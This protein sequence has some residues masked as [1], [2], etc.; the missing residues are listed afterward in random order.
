M[1]DSKKSGWLR[2]RQWRKALW[3]SIP[4]F[5]V[6]GTILSTL[7]LPKELGVLLAF[8]PAFISST[9]LQHYKCPRCGECFF[10]DRVWYP[11]RKNCAHCGLPKWE[12]ADSAHSK[13][14]NSHPE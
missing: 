6:L 3:V 4:G 1:S 13:N 9:A 12:E 5:F 11:W 8:L 2:Y 14:S 7:P 10:F